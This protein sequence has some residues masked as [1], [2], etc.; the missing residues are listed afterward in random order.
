[1]SASRRR[2]DNP[3]CF[4]FCTNF[5]ISP[6]TCQNVAWSPTTSLQK[7]VPC[8][9]CRMRMGALTFR[10]VSRE[11]TTTMTVSRTAVPSSLPKGRCWRQ[12]DCPGAS[13]V[14]SDE[15][16]ALRTN[17]VSARM[18]STCKAGLSSRKTPSASQEL[19]GDAQTSPWP[20]ALSKATMSPSA[21]GLPVDGLEAIVPTW[22]LCSGTSRAMMAKP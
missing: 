9:S 10:N 15:R 6:V 3:I 21:K 17:C 12:A 14:R 2:L 7:F 13:D 4:S 8:S 16:K 22:R 18:S 20:A 11:M 19:Y 5:A 1:M